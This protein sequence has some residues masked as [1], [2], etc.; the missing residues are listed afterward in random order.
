MERDNVLY[1]RGLG[2]EYDQSSAH[3]GWPGSPGN[4]GD[5]FSPSLSTLETQVCVEETCSQR[6]LKVH[7]TC[8]FCFHST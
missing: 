7:P 4:T 6:P 5:K 3:M 8:S 2:T 1:S